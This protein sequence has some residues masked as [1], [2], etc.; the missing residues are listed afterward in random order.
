MRKKLVTLILFGTLITMAACSG[1]DA[2][3][4]GALAGGLLQAK[5]TAQP[6]TA[7]ESKPTGEVTFGDCL[8]TIKMPNDG[9][10][11]SCEDDEITF[12]YY[13]WKYGVL[14]PYEVKAGDGFSELDVI[15]ENFAGAS[16]IVELIDTREE[17]YG[18]CYVLV[19]RRERYSLGEI[20]FL[21]QAGILSE[22][23]ALEQEQTCVAVMYRL[24][25]G[26]W[27]C[28][29]TDGDEAGGDGLL[30]ALKFEITFANIK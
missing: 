14:F 7:P 13:N 15:I 4:A 24:N 20:E 19:I 8:I 3:D 16:G 10:K 18:T 27:W 21:A 26:R 6:S 9:Y 2:A 29:M 1:R 12:N 30:D 23:K 28:F 25:E 17:E 22:E 11:I 5:N